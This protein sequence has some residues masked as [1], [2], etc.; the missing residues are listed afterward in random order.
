MKKLLF[1]FT[2]LFGFATQA[3]NEQKNNKIKAFIHV[4]TKDL[5]DKQPTLYKEYIATKERLKATTESM[6]S[7]WIN[8]ILHD[9][10]FLN[11]EIELAKKDRTSIYEAIYKKDQNNKISHMKCFPK[12]LLQETWFVSLERLEEPSKNGSIWALFINEILSDTDSYSVCWVYSV[13]IKTYY[14]YN[15]KPEE[16][17]VDTVMISPDRKTITVNFDTLQDT[18]EWRIS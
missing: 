8:A 18:I 12:N 17:D 1:A 7:R 16:K 13:K 6:G 15:F 5:E 14:L 11:A 4:C 2:L 3:M 9:K 10:R